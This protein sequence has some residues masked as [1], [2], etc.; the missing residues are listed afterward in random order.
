MKWKGLMAVLLGLAIILAM[1]AVSASQ[2]IVSSDYSYGSNWIMEL[3]GALYKDTGELDPNY[4]YYAVKITTEDINYRNDGWVGPMYIYADIA[5]LPESAAEVP[6]NHVPKSGTKF[7]QHSVSFSYE[8]IGLN[9][10]IP[11]AFVSYWEKNGDGAHHFIW[12]VSGAKPS[13]VGWWF[14]FN[15]YAEFAV[16]FRVPQ[17]SN[18]YTATYAYGDWYKLYGV[19]FKKLGSDSAVIGMSYSPA[20][21]HSYSKVN[22]LKYP[23]LIHDRNIQGL[24]ETI[25]ASPETQSLTG[26]Q[27]R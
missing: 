3:A 23:L 10:L 18:V 27:E 13:F 16:G 4:D 26:L 1:P 14:V 24:P 7:S 12:E 6:A 8:G 19:V 20:G 11:R 22:L 15:D 5:V 9:V 17:N 25:K 21:Y 2:E